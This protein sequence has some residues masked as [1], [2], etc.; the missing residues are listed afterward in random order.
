MQCFIFV[1]D[2]NCPHFSG[3]TTF[4]NFV[5]CISI[6]QHQLLIL[7]YSF[8]FCLFKSQWPD[9]TWGQD[10]PK[11]AFSLINLYFKIK[12][13]R[14]FAHPTLKSAV[15]CTKE[16]VGSQKWD[17]LLCILWLF[18]SNFLLE[19]RVRLITQAFPDFTNFSFLFTIFFYLLGKQTLDKTHKHLGKLQDSYFQCYLE[20][21]PYF[22]VF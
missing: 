2:E 19:L 12:E 14:S 11:T 4:L 5:S 15:T 9:T 7:C 8:I 16:V 6:V 1:I 20:A 13:G 10:T 22:C 18:F 17:F 21:I 3:Q